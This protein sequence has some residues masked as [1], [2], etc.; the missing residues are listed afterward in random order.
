MSGVLEQ[1]GVGP[2][3]LLQ[4]LGRLLE[5]TQ[6]EHVADGRRGLVGIAQTS[7]PADAHE[8]QDRE[9]NGRG[10]TRGRQDSHDRELGAN[11]AEAAR[12][13]VERE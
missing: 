7:V 4:E 9:Q 6:L 11:R 13:R 5:L 8:K 10:R 12:A 1:A 2:L 3:Q